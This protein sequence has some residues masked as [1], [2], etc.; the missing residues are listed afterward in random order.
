MKIALA[1][2]IATLSTAAAYKII[3]STAWIKTLVL[4][5]FR[6]ECAAQP[7]GTTNVNVYPPHSTAEFDNVGLPDADDVV[8]VYKAALDQLPQA[9]GQLVTVTHK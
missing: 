4:G 7:D 9:R 5:P 8:N 3:S 2:S 6:L 1:Y